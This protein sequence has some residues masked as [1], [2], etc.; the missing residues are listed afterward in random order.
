MSFVIEMK[1]SL[2]YIVLQNIKRKPYR[3]AAIVLCV[4][5]ATGVLFAAT[6]TMRSIQ[7]SLQVGLE[8]F[9]ADLIVIPRG[10]QVTTQ[11]AFIAGQ[12]TSFYMDQQIAK[13]VAMQSGVGRSSAQVFVQTLSN[14]KCCAGEFFLVGFEPGKDFTISPWLTT[15]L[16]GRALQPDEIIVGDRILLEPGET[17]IFYGSY[18]KVAGVLEPTGMGI[19]RTVFVPVEGL[20][21]MIAASPE[22][23]EQALTIAPNQISA[24]LVKVIPGTNPNQVAETIENNINGVQ[25][26][27]T[28][29]M[30]MAITKQF[31]GLL[32]IILAVIGMLWLMALITI[33]LIFTLIVNE[34]QRELGLLRAM[35]AR[36]GFVF[37][38]IVGE[39]MI[40]TG[41]GGV[42]G[43]LVS[44]SLFVGLQSVLEQN[45]QTPFLLPDSTESIVLVVF[46]LGL[47]L[48]SGVIA[49][50]QPALRI[51]RLEPYEA[52]RQGE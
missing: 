35:G 30:I 23:A 7:N 48:V 17:V 12:P 34:R 27:T 25:A 46:L 4:M 38:M 52:I 50:L 42:L 29:Q 11:E 19:D 9:G 3:T 40:L 2:P 20:R 45:L 10:Q 6:V 8:R 39:A 41:I 36:Q 21:Q 22:R 47:A 18:F 24:V 31:A 5:I 33:A 26:I 16:Q 51:S 37:R 44:A 49:S 43:L 14:A 32:N 13:Q 1:L 28:T 15:H